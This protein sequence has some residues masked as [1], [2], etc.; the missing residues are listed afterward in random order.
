MAS[1]LP[2]YIL[3]GGLS[4]RLGQD[5]ALAMIAGQPAIMRCVAP[6]RPLT[7]TLKVVGSRPAQYAS[8]G[9][10]TIVDRRAAW[11][12]LAGLERALEDAHACAHVWIMVVACDML[13]VAPQW[14]VQL[15]ASVEPGL[16]AVVF[17]DPSGRPQP[18]LGL[19]HVRAWPVIS[20]Q[21]DQGQRA[22]WRAL[23]AL[24]TR[25]LDAP[26]G[27]EALCGLNTPEELAL[28]RARYGAADQAQPRDKREQDDDPDDKPSQR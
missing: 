24:N 3:A 7:T 9:L 19:Y 8:L 5:K 22:V 12:P 21:L 17:R 23:L 27:W 11:G 18:L 28:A 14:F 20:A 26:P 2:L 4:T 1:N 16:D 15:M 25:Y 6:L 10:E 13:A